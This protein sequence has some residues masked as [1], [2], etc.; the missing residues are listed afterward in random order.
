MAG[1]I[2]NITS[3]DTLSLNGNV[4]ND[5]ADGDDVVINFPNQ[6]M[7]R[8]TG[9]NGNSIISQNANGLNADLVLRVM[10]GSSDDVFLNNLVPANVPDFPSTVLLSGTFIKRIGDGQG[11]VRSDVYVLAGGTVS[12]I[13]DAKENVE[14][15]TTQG[16]TIYNIIFASGQRSIG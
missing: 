14:G 13:P 1:Q 3:N 16:V 7:T 5:L 11:N 10:R 2:F 15:D 4:F 6:L 9:K 12:K 8:K